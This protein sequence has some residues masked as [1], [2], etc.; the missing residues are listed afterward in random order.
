MATR[1]STGARNALADTVGGWFNGGTLTIYGNDGTGQPASAD[2]T[3]VG[4]GTVLAVITL[5]A[6]AFAAA[7]SGVIALAGTWQDASADATGTAQWFRFTATGDAGGASTTAIRVD[8]AITAT[9]G[10]GELQLVSTSLTATQ[11]F[12]ITAFTVTIPAA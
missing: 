1:I 11:P 12:E 8:G 7:A 4:G 10:G 3:E 2:D 5:P 6:D 9:G